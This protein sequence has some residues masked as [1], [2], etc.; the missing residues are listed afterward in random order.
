MKRAGLLVAVLCLV[1]GACAGA[2]SRIHGGPSAA[3]AAPQETPLWNELVPVVEEATGRSGFFF[4]ESGLESY[5]VRL[6]A[7]EAATRTVDIQYY[8]WKFDA[9]GRAISEALLRAAER[10]V[11]VRVLV[12]GFLVDNHSKPLKR[13][14]RHPNVEVRIYNAFRTSFWPKLLR[15]PELAFDFA[16]LNQRMHNKILAVDNTVAIVGG[17]NVNDAYFGLDA[18]HYFLDRDVV[19]AGPLTPQISESFD[20]FWNSRYAVSVRDFGGDEEDLSDMSAL[21]SD[22]PPFDPDT[23]VLPRFIAG[24]ELMDRFGELRSR[25]V[26]APGTL[27]LTAPGPVFAE[28]A[29]LGEPRIETVLLEELDAARREILIQM[30][31]VMLTDERDEALLR[32]QARGVA[33]TLQTNSLASHDSAVVHYGYARDRVRLAR[34]GVA[35][36]EAKDRPRASRGMAL[37]GVTP[38][39]T[40][41]HPKTLVFD[42]DRVFVGSFNLDSRSILYNSEIGILIESPVLAGRVADA[43]AG[44]IAPENSWRVVVEP[45]RRIVWLDE[46]ADPPRRLHSEPNAGF[47]AQLAAWL[48]YFLPIDH[49]L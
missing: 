15:Y 27:S 41:L 34:L 44:D 8:I 21:W 31:Y 35:L 18:T 16:R 10:G 37:E 29:A 2:P 47:F 36:H 46:S 43:I 1:L 14:A 5:H 13:I 48:G 40:T 33:T 3:L 22:A 19:V 32:A 7:I 42:R 23:F 25:F 38:E 12:D 49:L 9:S 39:K 28:Q 45:P 30:S 26:W 6:T 4:L 20:A 11:R 24:V 17:R